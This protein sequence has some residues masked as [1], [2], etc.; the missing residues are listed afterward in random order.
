MAAHHGGLQTGRIYARYLFALAALFGFRVVAQLLQAVFE[1]PMLPSFAAW[2]SGAL[3]YPALV[4]SQVVILTA[5]VVIAWRVRVGALSPGRWRH[6]LCFGLGGL[7]FSVM[8]FRLLAGM[9]WLSDVPWFAKPLPAF[10]HL[11]LAS[12]L[13]VLGL[14][15]LNGVRHC[16]T[17]APET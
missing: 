4:A 14:Y 8:L 16:Q 15:F 12:Y 13:L 9:T 10:F 11:G 1:L 5:M 17:K 7:Y 2:H 6:R 3:P